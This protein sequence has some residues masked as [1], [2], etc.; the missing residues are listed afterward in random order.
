MLAFSYLK[1]P[2]VS[3]NEQIELGRADV[4][5]QRAVRVG[6]CSRGYVQLL[7]VNKILLHH[8]FKNAT[9]LYCNSC[10]N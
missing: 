3:T 2:F 10:N 5:N 8:T 1:S 4:F 7:T 6:R 9:L